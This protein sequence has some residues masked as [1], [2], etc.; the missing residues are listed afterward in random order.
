MLATL[1]A[2]VAAAALA[3][4]AEAHPLGNNSVNH[5]VYVKVFDNRVSLLYLLDQAE[6]PTLRD[7]RAGRPRRFT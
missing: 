6:Y 2:A 1:T 7:L 3:P 4:K 5:L